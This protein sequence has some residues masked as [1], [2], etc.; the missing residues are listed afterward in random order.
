MA[1]LSPRTD[2]LWLAGLCAARTGASMMFMAYP[3]VLPM[4]QQE[5][6]LSGTAAGSISSASRFGTA[7]SLAVLSALA[8]RVGAR[9]VFLWSACFSAVVALLLPILAQGYLSAL[10]LFGSL[11]VCLAGTYTPGLILLAD[12][13]PTARRGWAIGWFIASGS[14]GYALALVGAGFV[15]RVAGWRMALF[16]LALGPLICAILSFAI[17]RGPAQRLP[18]APPASWRLRDDLIRNRPAQL[19]IA[20]YTFHSWELLGM[21]AWTPAFLAAVLGA[22]GLEL[23]RAT[24]LGANLTAAFHVM[25]IVATS[26]GGWLSDRWGR[27]AVIIGM[28]TVSTACSLTFGWLLDAPLALVV[29]VGLIYGFS[30]IGDSPVYS[31]GITEVVEPSRLGT[32]F[33]VR[34]LVGFGA[35][36]VAPLIFGAVLDL[37]AGGGPPT[38]GIWGWAFAVLGVGGFLGICSMLWLRALPESRRLAGGKR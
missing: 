3:A 19:M 32:V 27:T 14:S 4:I 33:A 15:V 16:T 30:A 29:V 24:G 36:G 35:G 10:V 8:D 17:M 12:R 38:G 21:W 37:T 1:A 18:A 34:S 28:M 23:S 6:E 7:V 26:V 9:T 31:T 20:G 25:G 13:F 2:T 11:A 5:W 22:R